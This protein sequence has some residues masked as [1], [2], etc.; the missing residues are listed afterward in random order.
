MCDKHRSE[1]ADSSCVS[2]PLAGRGII[3]G[4]MELKSTD[5]LK[6]LQRAH[7]KEPARVEA[8]G[9]SAVV[10][11]RGGRVREVQADEPGGT[12]QTFQFDQP[13]AGSPGPCR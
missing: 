10:E 5:L 4:H 11:E 12:Q 13:D 2:S 3:S 7:E 8:P 6:V 9:A 1:N